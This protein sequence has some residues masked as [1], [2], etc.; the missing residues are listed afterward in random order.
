MNLEHRSG[1]PSFS[2]PAKTRSEFTYSMVLNRIEIV[3]LNR[4]TASVTNDIENVLRKIEAWHQGSIAGYRIMYQDTDG[5]WDGVEW[6]GEHARFFAIRETDEVA[7]EK[8]LLAHQV[9]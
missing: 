1:S 6:N 8:K 2:N 9:K 7:A 3:D 4:G 5:Y